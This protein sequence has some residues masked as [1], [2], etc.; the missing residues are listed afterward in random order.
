MTVNCTRC[1]AK[2]PEQDFDDHE[3]KGL[4]PLSEMSD[5]YLDLVALKVLTEAEAWEQME[6]EA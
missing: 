3:C 2:M 4:R 6:L 5:K 1:N